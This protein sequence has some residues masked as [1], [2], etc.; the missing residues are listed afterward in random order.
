LPGF[1]AFNLS[2]HLIAMPS[3]KLISNKFKDFFDVMCLG[4]SHAATLTKGVESI[5]RQKGL[6]L[7]EK[8]TYLVPKKKEERKE[9][10][11]KL[12]ALIEKKGFE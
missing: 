12:R 5:L 9:L 3:E 2:V 7:V 11:T 4:F 10:N 1:K 6:L 8:G